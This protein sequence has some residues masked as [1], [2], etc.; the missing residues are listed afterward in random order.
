MNFNMRS[1]IA[2][3]YLLLG[4]FFVHSLFSRTWSMNDWHQAPASFLLIKILAP[5]ISI[6][7]FLSGISMRGIGRKSLR[8]VL[9]QSLMLIFLAWVSEGVGIVLVDLAYGAYGHG[10]HFIRQAVKPMVYGTGGCTFVT[11]FFTVLAAGRILVWL[12]ERN[13]IYFVCAWAVIIGLILVGKR[14]HLPDNLYEW[15]NWPAATLFIVI[16]M[17]LPRDWR[18]PSWAG[19]GG[20]LGGL[21]LTWFNVPG[22][23]K[24]APCLA[25]NIN[26]VAEPMVGQYGFLPVF[27]AEQF[28]MFLFII[29]GGAEPP[30]ADRQAGQLFRSGLAAIPAA[31]W[32]AARHHHPADHELPA[33]PERPCRHT[34]DADLQPAAARG[35]FQIYRAHAE[36]GAGALLQLWQVGDGFRLQAG[37]A[38]GG[39]QAAGATLMVPA[40][41]FS[42]ETGL[43]RRPPARVAAG[44]AD[45]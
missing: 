14:L 33:A 35:D 40:L 25:C 11:W 41:E 24:T 39:R 30:G 10:I 5:Q 34:G 31:A 13:K 28:L 9:P 17:K 7:F 2:R 8:A 12:F 32:L 37:R 3:G 16:G 44:D 4:V 6:Y 20:L 21:V 19:L 22:M 26:F 18:V 27:I 45:G 42:V 15:R 29:L 36:P 38:W 1:E 43:A 23:W